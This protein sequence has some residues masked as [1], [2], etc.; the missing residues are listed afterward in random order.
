MDQIKSYVQTYVN[1]YNPEVE[2][3]FFLY[4]SASA[5]PVWCLNCMKFSDDASG[6]H[7]VL[8]YY[9]TTQILKVDYEKQ[10]A[11]QEVIGNYSTPAEFKAYLIETGIPKN[12]WCFTGF[13]FLPPLPRLYESG[14]SVNEYTQVPSRSFS[15]LF[16]TTQSDLCLKEDV[17]G[18]NRVTEVIN[19]ED[20]TS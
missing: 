4:K 3:Q 7:V 8:F 20:K 10:K 12:R 9:N 2:W 11:L 14:G 15:L 17:Q 19:M 13:A 6:Q 16:W 5:Y 1:G 18:D